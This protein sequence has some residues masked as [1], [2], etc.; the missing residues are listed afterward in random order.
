MKQRSILVT[1]LLCVLLLTGCGTAAPAPNATPT[2]T[3]EAAAAPTPTPDPL[4]TLPYEDGQLYAAAYLG[5]LE[6][7]DLDFF[8]QTYFGGRELR[9][10]T[11]DGAHAL[12]IGEVRRLHG[13][14][15]GRGAVR[16]HDGIIIER[17][18][19]VARRADAI[20]RGRSGE[21]DGLHAEP[22]QNKVEP[23]VEKRRKPR[24]YEHIVL[25]QNGER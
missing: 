1:L 9:A 10:C 20:G 17:D 11:D 5:Y 22:P 25:R 4:S 12:H 13:I 15:D 21:Q 14:R 8:R 24:L 23:G 7:K 18:R 2:P 6:P 3:Q 19:I 16:E